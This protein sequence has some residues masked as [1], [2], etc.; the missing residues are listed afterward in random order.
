MM[1][2]VSRSAPLF[3]VVAV[4]TMLVVGWLSARLLWAGSDFILELP[5][6]RWPRLDNI[7]TGHWRG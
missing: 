7:L 2:G 6:I 3:S 4:T 5:P 1:A